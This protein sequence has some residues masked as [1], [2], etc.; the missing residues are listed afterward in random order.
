MRAAAIAAADA[1]RGPRV[2]AAG[3]RA[4]RA[5]SSVDG[6]QVT[7]QTS[8]IHSLAWHPIEVGAVGTPLRI[9]LN[10]RTQT[11]KPWPC[12]RRRGMTTTPRRAMQTSFD[13]SPARRQTQ[14]SRGPELRKS[15]AAAGRGDLAWVRDG[16]KPG[17]AHCDQHHRGGKQ[18]DT[19]RERKWPPG[20]ATRRPSRATMASRSASSRG[21]RSGQ[22]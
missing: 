16:S 21:R 22:R 13:R 6:H 19:A 1:R 14:P 5:S 17:R 4:R 8:T 3:R 12:C 2:S 10:T 9:A 18:A 20:L 7:G 11:P 15:T